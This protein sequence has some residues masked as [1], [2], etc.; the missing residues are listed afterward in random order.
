MARWLIALLVLLSA[1]PP[2][3]ADHKPAAQ[4]SLIGYSADG[5]YL[6]Y[7][8]FGI[9]PDTGH[10]FAEMHV[11]DVHERRW[12]LGS[13]LREES[14]ETTSENLGA[15]RYS[16]FER[17]MGLL[18]DLE[19]VRPAYVAAL[20][21]DG[22][23]GGRNRHIAFSVPAIS[24]EV[25]DLSLTL[26]EVQAASTCDTMI[27]KDLAKGFAVHMK[28]FGRETELYRDGPLS[29]ARGCPTDY[30]L[31]AIVL[32]FDARDLAHAVALVAADLAGSSGS[33]RSFVPV[34]LGAAAAER[35]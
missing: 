7:E 27:G 12:V 11:L 20:N 3:T 4:F 15:L 9:A 14:H 1:V 28:G 18:R 17:A 10:A 21:G 22:V 31:M 35:L 33:R 34:P 24:P 26:H 23:P 13:P 30:R 6:A 32:P 5:R 19:I 25:I 16:V 2:V 8:E 29:R